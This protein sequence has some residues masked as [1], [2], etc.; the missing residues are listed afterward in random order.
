MVGAGW[1]DAALSFLNCRKNPPSLQ[2]L[3]MTLG[4]AFLSLAAFDRG[5]GR[6]GHVLHTYGRVPLFFYLAH[7]AVVHAW[8]SW[9]RSLQGFPI[10]WMFQ[11]PSFQYPP[12]YGSGLPTVY[13]A[14]V[15]TVVLMYI[16]C[17]WYWRR[18]RGRRALRAT[19]SGHAQ[20]PP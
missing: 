3:L 14:W 1:P 2:F 17:R 19:P 20:P 18:V 10:G 7:W 11:F 4:P 6:P 9:S 8:P 15:V 5:L 12:G 13:A 16:P